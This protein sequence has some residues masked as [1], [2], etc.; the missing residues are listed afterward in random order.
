MGKFDAIWLHN[1]QMC[2]VTSCLHG[3]SINTLDCLCGR[4]AAY[5]SPTFQID[6]F[7]QMVKENNLNIFNVKNKYDFDFIK[8]PF[9]MQG[10]CSVPC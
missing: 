10:L 1:I 4:V 9:Y 5:I 2:F 7:V 3:L 6:I 8:S